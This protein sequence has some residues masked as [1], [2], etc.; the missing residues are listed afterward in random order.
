MSHLISS[1]SG[2][3]PQDLIIMFL[4]HLVV[5]QYW[6]FKRTR[7]STLKYLKASISTFIEHVSLKIFNNSLIERFKNRSKGQSIKIFQF[8]SMKFFAVFVSIFSFDSVLSSRIIKS[9]S[10]NRNDAVR[11]QDQQN[12]IN[13]ARNLLETC[14]LNNSEEYCYQ[15]IFGSNYFWNKW[16]NY[17]LDLKHKYS[18]DKYYNDCV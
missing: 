7:T 13:S 11:T 1:G 16:L 10:H 12:T 5:F 14:K 17:V 2:N 6:M 3:P 9:N 18:I 15:T 8:E 4:P